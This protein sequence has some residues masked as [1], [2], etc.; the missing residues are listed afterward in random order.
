MTKRVRARFL[1]G[2]VAAALLVSCGP[3]YGET[4]SRQFRGDGF[5]NVGFGKGSYGYDGPG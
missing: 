5:G 4:G 2:I 3:D 1:L